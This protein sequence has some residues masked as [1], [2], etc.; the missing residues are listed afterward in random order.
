MID[1]PLTQHYTFT[2]ERKYDAPP[3]RVFRAFAN[4]DEKA[5]WFVGP[6]GWTQQIR[7]QDFRPG[8]S[9]RV[10]GT[11]PAGETSDFEVTYHDILENQ[12]IVFYYDMHVNE[13]HISASLATVEFDD[14]GGQTRLKYTE[15]AVYLDGWLTPDDREEGNAKL[16][17]Q[18]EA[19]LV[20]TKATA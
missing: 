18:L 6:R 2:I 20:S 9:E 4:V 1:A 12:R 3:Q 11:F 14:V 7:E 8:G 10:R 15:H 17:D 13:R 19:Y 16:L 5:K